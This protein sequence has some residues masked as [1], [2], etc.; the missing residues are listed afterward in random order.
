MKY[1]F[2]ITIVVL[3]FSCATPI[4]PPGGPRDESPPQ[5]ELDM[6]RSGITNYKGDRIE[7][8]F[9]EYIVFSGGEDKII[10]TP[11]MPEKPKYQV[12][13]KKLI[14][15][16]P[17][18]LE[19][20]ITYSISFM[21]AIGDF[22]EGN[23]LPL[24]R[25]VFATGEKI[26]SASL[27]GSV[28]NA[29]DL[30]PL[31]NVFVG[32]YKLDASVDYKSKPLYVTRTNAQGQFRLD[33]V[34]EGSYYLGALED[35]NYNY[36]FDQ[37]TERLSIPSDLIEVKG[38]TVLDKA[39]SLFKN[40]AKV[41]VDG[42]KL[43]DN[44][45]LC[46]YFSEQVDDLGLDVEEYQESDKVYFSATNDTLFYHW[47]S[48]TLKSLTFNF[49]LNRETKDTIV[50]PLA[51][52]VL[53]LALTTKTSIASNERIILHTPKYISEV[54]TASIT[55]KDSVN[56]DISYKIT[57]EREQ[58]IFRLLDKASSSITLSIDSGCIE[59]YD[60]TFNE[61]A[62]AKR[63]VLEEA[64]DPAK[65]ILSFPLEVRSEIYLQ[66]LNKDKALL[67]S[68][69]IDNTN[70]LILEGLKPSTYYIRVFSDVNMNGKWTTGNLEK[71]LA[72]EATLLFSKPIEVKDNWDK[73]IDLSF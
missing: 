22:T 45:K 19:N 3:L 8:L 24:L 16:L 58:L 62:F 12:K 9:D 53:D 52:S 18:N 38:N 14:V 47:S 64:K 44:K 6:P 48:D 15:K 56:K 27:S 21:D 55:L 39:L 68:Y 60:G 41:K 42:Y 25:Y 36:I 1:F 34:K 17:E 69:K 59:Y 10:I 73:E 7:F 2:S 29:F 63:I 71:G 5:V 30:I 37:G 32:L 20:D 35:K 49:T 43:L 70:T 33:Y 40:E 13:G 54:N 61:K 67:E 26:D 4:A 51:K 50:V 28:I 66:L 46:F 23:K 31:E 65:L 57:Q 11:E 72:P